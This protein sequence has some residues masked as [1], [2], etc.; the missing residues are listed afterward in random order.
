MDDRRHTPRITLDHE[1]TVTVGGHRSARLV[2]ISVAGV[3]LEL[4]S[5]LHPTHVCQIA[6]PL[7]DGSVKIKARVAHCKATGMS[8]ATTGG[9][10]VYR[11]G[12][13]FVDADRTV[14]EAIMSAYAPRPVRPVESVEPVEPIKPEQPKRRGPIKIKVNVDALARNE[15]S[16]KHGAN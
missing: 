8:T 4:A 6:V 9:G 13:E 15:A 2:D 10:L 3:H 14:T 12:L 5:A 11:A 16:S 1:I 7:P